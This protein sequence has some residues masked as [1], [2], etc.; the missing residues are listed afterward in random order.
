MKITNRI[1]NVVSNFL[2]TGST[3]QS[4]LG[5]AFL[6][7]GNQKP[8]VQDW[9]QVIMDDTQL[10]QGY[11]YAAI[12][13]RANKVAQI[14]IENLKT[15]QGLNDESDKNEIVHPYLEIIDKSSTFSNYEFWYTISTY[16]DLEGVYYLMAVRN[17]SDS[18]R[19]GNIQEFKLINPYNVRRILN[20]DG[21]VGGYVETK[22]GLIR[23]L[24]K[25]MIIPIVKLNP[26]N[27]DPYAITD[28]A[29]EY[30]YALKQAGDYTRHA[31]KSNM[32]APGIVS[33][34]VILPDE[35][36]ANFVARVKGSEKGVPLFGNGEGSIKW[37]SM[38]LDL[39]KSSLNDINEINRSTLFAVSGVGK[40]IMGIEESGTTRETSKVQKDLF[41][42]NHIIPQLQLVVDAFNQDYK[43]NYE[44]KNVNANKQL[45]M[46]ID[47]PLGV[48][49]DAEIKDK[50]LE[51]KDIEKKKSE[52][53]LYNSLAA[54]FYTPDSIKAYLN[55]EIAI[56]ELRI[57]EK[58]KKE[59]ESKAPEMQEQLKPKENDDIEDKEEPEPAEDINNALIK[60]LNEIQNDL[61]E[62]KKKDEEDSQLEQNYSDKQPRDSD[63]KWS[64][65]YSTKYSNL[66][67]NEFS[68]TIKKDYG[69]QT[70]FS[71]TEVEEIDGYTDMG[72]AYTNEDLIKAN[73][74]VNKLDDYRKI[75][76]NTL[77]K[78]MRNKLKENTILYRGIHTDKNI[79]PGSQV[80]TRGYSSA[81]FFKT[82]GE[83]FATQEQD[84]IFDTPYLLSIKANKGQKGI[85]PILTGR[86]N[87][88]QTTEAEFI[89]PRNLKLNVIERIDGDN[90]VEL[91]TE[92]AS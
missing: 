16:I 68:S 48:D 53:E 65:G 76:V 28:A 3:E 87:G 59:G 45:I 89:L 44:N 12:N 31:I 8:L 75:T 9:S 82:K 42:E 51:I 58:A 27:N 74:N 61:V 60:K 62:L 83:S 80:F 37:Q 21:E 81:S 38:Q 79:Q 78:S 29:K 25:E 14:A 55:N 36:F 50:D 47:S 54:L 23:E 40:T 24:P 17:F 88:L 5:N 84:R 64:K 15:K 66:T 1:K 19:I 33:T 73:G 72:F 77:D 35:Q 13:V 43:N 26:F 39:D 4:R 22:N 49:I 52:I 92:I 57:D 56:D 46:Y 11:S 20:E 34:D 67:P 41:V 7:Y 86:D 90:Y 85:I 10:Y 71:K 63:G 70:T 30:Q 18:G 2:N 6:R 32:S 69:N 91:V